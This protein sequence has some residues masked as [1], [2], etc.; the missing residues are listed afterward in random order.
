MKY[1][2]EEN[3]KLMLQLGILSKKEGI[4]SHKKSVMPGM[5][6]LV[7]ERNQLLDG[8]NDQD[9]LGFSMAHY[10]CQNGDLCSDPI[11]EILYYPK[12]ELVEAFSFEISIPP[13]YQLVFPAEIA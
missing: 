2:Y 4:H 10:F 5:M 9:C 7:V 13:T 8:Y 11:M 6:D 1:L 12:S 3:F